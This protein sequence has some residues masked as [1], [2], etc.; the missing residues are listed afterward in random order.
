[1]GSMKDV[2]KELRTKHVIDNFVKSEKN[3]K[4]AIQFALQARHVM[5]RAWFTPSELWKGVGNDNQKRLKIE[6]PKMDGIQIME[7]KIRTC[8][9][10]GLFRMK[11]F[12][13]VVKYRSHLAAIERARLRQTKDIKEKEAN[14]EEKVGK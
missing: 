11:K 1:M 9:L 8:G 4:E 13:R 5:G 10:F 12:K 2:T 3:Q 14:K 7:A 6:Y